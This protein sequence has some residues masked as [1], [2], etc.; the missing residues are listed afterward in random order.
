V[1]S[2]LE[3]PGGRP[4]DAE[5]MRLIASGS[6]EA[7][8]HLYD[9]YSQRAYRVALSVCRER[10]LAE[11]AVQDVFVAIWRNRNSY[12]P[13]RGTVAA[14]LLSSARYRAIDSARRHDKHV[15]RRADESRIDADRFV[16]DPAEGAVSDVEAAH[17]RLL[18]NRLPDAQREV[19]TLAFY[20][21]LTHTEIADHLQLS[22]GTIKGRMRL[23][24]EKLRHKV[25]QAA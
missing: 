14:W 10:G 7:F 22:A 17:L 20:G 6:I 3:P 9:R 18:L 25:E 12:R 5:L 2:D 11:E 21:Q 24:L 8:E 16:E 13:E 15:K 1:S 4:D 23:G 19:I